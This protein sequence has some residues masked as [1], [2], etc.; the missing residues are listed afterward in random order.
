VVPDSFITYFVVNVGASAALIG[1]LFVAVTVAPERIF[2]R[3]RTVKGLVLASSAFIALLD[4]FFVSM[5]AV[6]PKANIGSAV[7][8]M[9]VLALLNTLSMA[10]HLW[11]DRHHTPLTQGLLLL[12]GSLVIY[13]YEINFGVALLQ[14]ARDVQAVQGLAYLLLGVYAVGV[15]RTWMLLGG[16]HEGLLSLLGFVEVGTG[17]APLPQPDEQ[18]RDGDAVPVPKGV[19]P[20]G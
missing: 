2:G 4:A 5:V 14:N 6:I 9:G 16:Q 18:V 11:V 13:S 15:A 12:L 17:A 20:P 3:D 7:L 1:L 10:R 19:V 8:V